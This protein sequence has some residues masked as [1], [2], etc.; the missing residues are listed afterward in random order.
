MGTTAAVVGGV[1]SAAKT[2]MD[3]KNAK[4]EKKLAKQEERIQEDTIKKKQELFEEEKRNLLKSKVAS[5]KAQMASSGVDFTDGSSAVLL[6]SMEREAENEIKNKEY[7]SDL[8]LSSNEMNYNYKKNKNL[9]N[10]R[11]KSLDL[12]D[13]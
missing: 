5:K 9:L 12:L 3:I 1:V 6:G 8:A 7:F 10:M 13:S 2:V 4:K 11:K